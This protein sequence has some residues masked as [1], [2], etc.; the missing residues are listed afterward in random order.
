MSTAPLRIVIRPA[1]AGLPPTRPLGIQ[2]PPAISASHNLEDGEVAS[3]RLH[4]LVL[5]RGV[6]RPRKRDP[7]L[8]PC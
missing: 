2:L 4:H 7:V 5:A 6:L 3:D 1:H 8:G